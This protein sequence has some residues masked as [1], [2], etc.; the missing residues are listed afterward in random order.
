MKI[1]PVFVALLTL[2]LLPASAA[3]LWDESAARS[4]APDAVTNPR[5]TELLD[6]SPILPA[7]ALASQI[8]NLAVD[9]EL[10]L[11][12]RERI[13]RDYA[14]QL[15]EFVPD[16]VI[17]EQL[18]QLAL[19]QSRVQ[20]A[21]P[22]SRGS[23]GIPLYDVS[24]AALGTLNVWTRYSAHA[25]AAAAINQRDASGLLDLIDGGHRQQVAGAADAMREGSWSDVQHVAGQLLDHLKAVPNVSAL[26]QA[27]GQ[28][29]R[30]PVLLIALIE[31]G[32]PP[33]QMQTLT[34]LQH[35]IDIDQAIDVWMDVS[36]GSD[37]TLAAAAVLQL[38][39]QV[40][41]RPEVLE[42]MK[43]ALA[44]PDIGS[45]AALALSQIDDERLI[46]ELAKTMA[47][48]RPLLTRQRAL[49]ALRLSKHPLAAEL[50][51]RFARDSQHELAREARK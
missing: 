40:S 7:D 33:W 38:G 44:D 34:S 24:S 4:A 29:N 26:V 22:E 51:A 6:L 46:R 2:T 14:Y 41:R 5:V 32:H 8:Q 27:A 49:L 25:V 20:V 17:R 19:F 3:S 45:A 23:H 47:G 39:S 21:H 13:L 28:T 9:S 31:R 50:L 35:W 43:T 1:I 30:D 18:E 42:T 15:R 11:P 48:D 10:P 36:A 12:A 37:T 16:L